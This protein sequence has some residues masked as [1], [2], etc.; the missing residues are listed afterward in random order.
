MIPL[1]TDLFDYPLPAGAIA[2][3]PAAERDQSRLLVVD[4]QA[5]TL[6][7]HR[8]A[9]LP[10]FLRLGDTLFRNVAA[11]LPARLRAQR[12]TGGRIECL[13]L[14][15][16]GDGVWRCLVK[17]G[18][19]L[20]VGATFAD[21][22]GAFRGEILAW[23]EEGVAQVR[24]IPAQ[25]ES[26]TALA[27]RLGDVPLPPYIERPDGTRRAEDLQRYQTVYADPARPV[28]AAAPT[29]GLHFTPPLL[30]TL[31]AQG[32]RTADL[33]LQVGLG[34]FRPIATPTIEAQAIHREHFEIPVATQQALFP[35]APAGGR[36]IAVGTTVVRAIESFLAAEKTPLGQPY[37]GE[38]G[39]YLYPP[40]TFRGVDGLITNFHQ[41]RSTLLC[42]VSAFLAPGSTDGI[43][44]L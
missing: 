34:T 14:Q 5:R 12:P 1:S 29:A 6:A 11:V 32:V 4:R 2:Q 30:A 28:A 39:I 7:H 35:A 13:L 31:A 24:L 15:E 3:V 33:I 21:P 27:Q 19:K 36:R 17:P 20:P 8:F 40:A 10:A 38:A 18:R 41:P 22:G 23:G 25:G 16:I 37:L 44:W 43:A 9:D 26:V 42:L